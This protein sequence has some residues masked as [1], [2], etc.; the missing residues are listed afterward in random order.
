MRQRII[1]AVDHFVDI[2]WEPDDLVVNRIRNDGIDILIDLKG[3]TVGDR[4]GIMAQRASPIQV[5]WL[6]YPG[7]TGT[8]FVDY[9]IADP[10]IV[11]AGAEDSCTEQVLRQPHCY[12]PIDRKRVVAEPLA[13]AAYGLPDEGLVLCCFNQTFKITPAVFVTWMRILQTL[14]DSVLWLVDDNPWATANLRAAASAAGINAERLIFAPRLPLARHLARYQVADLALDTFP[15]TSHTTASDAL[16]CGCPLVALCGETFAARVSGSILTA[17]QLP[18][19]IATSL[20]D[21]E[22]KVLKLATNR[23]LLKD[24]ARRVLES[25]E[26]A[27]LFD[28]AAFTRDLESLYL[29]MQ[30]AKTLLQA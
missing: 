29:Q 17:A 26:N 5:T 20:E 16:W 21:Y 14:P 12:Q 25:R 24:V 7:T 2:A 18:A 22:S 3:Y 23:S 27:P 15:Y 4:L 10:Y 11:P 19:L 13:R 6:G 8:E 28:T 30:P 1:G 9:L